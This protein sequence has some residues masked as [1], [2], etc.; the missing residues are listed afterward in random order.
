M[1]FWKWAISTAGAF[2]LVKNGIF[3][4]MKRDPIDYTATIAFLNACRE[5]LIFAN[6]LLGKDQIY[7]RKQEIEQAIK[8]LKKA[9]QF[10][11]HPNDL[12]SKDTDSSS[13]SIS[14]RD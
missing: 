6:R 4:S 1:I 9:E 3:T 12:I 2:F 13:L 11:I 10:D 8:W 7:L 14:K 5:E